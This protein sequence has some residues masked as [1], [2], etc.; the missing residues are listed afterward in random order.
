MKK[1]LT[2][3]L[4]IV[5]INSYSQIQSLDS[6]INEWIGKPYKFGGKT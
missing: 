1:V 4:L 6:F 2:T 5:S 3:I